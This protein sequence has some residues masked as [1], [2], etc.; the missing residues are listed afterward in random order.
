MIFKKITNF[1]RN[2]KDR[3]YANVSMHGLSLSPCSFS[4]WV[5]D[6]VEHVSLPSFF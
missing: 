5:V 4:S 3:N 1:E 6:K 2:L